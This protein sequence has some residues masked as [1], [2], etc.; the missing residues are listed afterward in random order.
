M[1][2]LLSLLMPRLRKY[3]GLHLCRVLTRPLFASSPI[4][5]RSPTVP[6][7]VLGETELLAWCADPELDLRA[8]MVRGALAQ[9]ESCV[10]A[11]IEGRLVGYAWLAYG[12]GSYNENVQ[13]VIDPRSRYTYKVF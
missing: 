7:R 1:R 8:S 13:V 5:E 12:A 2:A 6:C 9:G 11:F 10:G 3:V 4:G